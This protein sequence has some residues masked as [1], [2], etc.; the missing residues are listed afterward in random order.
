VSVRDPLGR[1]AEA[2]AEPLLLLGSFVRV[3]IQGRVLDGVAALDRRLLRDGDRVWV[4]RT[5]GTLDIRPVSVAF[6]GDRRVLIS[7]GLE[8]GERVVTTD[9][10]AP[11]DGMPLRLR[12]ERGDG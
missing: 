11:V 4:M 6:G 12:E 9:L 10:P 8:D 3:E 5:D 2:G 7:H 1:E